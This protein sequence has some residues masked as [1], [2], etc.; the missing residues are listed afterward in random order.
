MLSVKTKRAFSKNLNQGKYKAL[1][2]Q[3]R[4]LGVIRS[5]VWQR[6]GSIKGVGLQEDKR[7]K[8]I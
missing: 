3:A 7:R 6:F 8:K 1:R 2:E 4:R 5:E